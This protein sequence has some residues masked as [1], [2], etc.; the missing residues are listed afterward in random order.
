MPKDA[1]KTKHHHKEE[2]SQNAAMER[3]MAEY[4]QFK[5]FLVTQHDYQGRQ[6]QQTAM[7]GTSGPS[8]EAG[9]GRECA[10]SMMG[11]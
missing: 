6:G 11:Y 9:N 10:G 2:S 5:D 8:E 7:M 1:T 4:D 3:Y